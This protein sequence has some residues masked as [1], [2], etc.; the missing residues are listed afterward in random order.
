MIIYQR[1]YDYVTSFEKNLKQFFFFKETDGT[2]QK[3]ITVLVSVK[4]KADPVIYCLEPNL[5]GI[6]FIVI[7]SYTSYIIID[8]IVGD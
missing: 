3:G 7:L 8:R 1:N 2:H 6:V 5:W 4:S